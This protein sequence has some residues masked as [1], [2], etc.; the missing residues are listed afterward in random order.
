MGTGFNENFSTFNTTSVKQ[1]VLVMFAYILYV[2]II[3][4]TH[5]FVFDDRSQFLDRCL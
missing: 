4:P 5:N 1:S 2:Y 3:G